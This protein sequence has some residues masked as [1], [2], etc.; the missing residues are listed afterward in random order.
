MT[1]PLPL[2]KLIEV[3][4]KL[5]GIGERSATRIAFFLLREPE[6]REELERIMEESGKA[7]LFCSKCHSVSTEDPC[8]ICKD[9]ERERKLLCVVERPLDVFIIEK[10]GLFKG[11]YHVLGGVISPIDGVSPKDL[12]I[13]DLL[14]RIRREKI[15]EVIIAL[16]PTTEGDATTYYLAEKLK[17]MKVKVTRIARGLPTGSDISFFDMTTL[18]EAI[19]GRKE[20]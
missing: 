6:V 5:P 15:E 17:E 20:I 13:A 19:L 14:E 8:P 1:L 3:L 2:E 7:L 4:K 11:R 18:K 10:L 16:S 12:Y 9:R